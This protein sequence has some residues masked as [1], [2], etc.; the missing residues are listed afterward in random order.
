M[1]DG[2]QGHCLPTASKPCIGYHLV[3][4]GFSSSGLTCFRVS[5]DPEARSLSEKKACCE[6]ESL[7]LYED[8]GGEPATGFV[9]KTTAG[10]HF[11]RV[12]HC[13]YGGQSNLG[14]SQRELVVSL[15]RAGMPATFHHAMNSYSACTMI[16]SPRAVNCIDPDL[17]LC[18]ERRAKGQ[19][20]SLWFRLCKIGTRKT[21]S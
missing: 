14:L 10:Q 1:S 16:L 20:T 9:L 19:L 8:S 18:N 11:H 3:R 7:F 13:A 15:L 6:D 4:S 12:L 2:L 17:S 5:K 21:L